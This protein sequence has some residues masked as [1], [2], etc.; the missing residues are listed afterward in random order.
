MDQVTNELVF[1]TGSELWFYNFR[2]NKPQLV[3]RGTTVAHDFMVRS[4]IGYGFI[5]D[6]R[7]L[8]IVELDTRDRQN[9]YQ[10]LKEKSVYQIAI[11]ENQ[12]TIVALQ[13]GSLVK[14]ELRD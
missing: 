3:T 9:R 2:T 10:V 12:K 11:T 13:D 14:I 8:E 1:S 4:N 6:S 7:G 5:A